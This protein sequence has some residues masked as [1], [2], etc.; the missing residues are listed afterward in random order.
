MGLSPRVRGNLT[1][2]AWANGVKRSIPACT[3]EPSRPRLPLSVARVYPRVYGG[4]FGMRSVLPVRLGLSPRVRG[5]LPDAAR[6]LLDNRSIPACAGEPAINRESR[7][8][9]W[10]YPRVCGGTPQTER[11]QTGYYGL[12]PRVRGNPEVMTPGISLQRSIPACAGEPAFFCHFSGKSQVYPRV[13]GGT[14]LKEGFPCINKGL[15]PR[16][17]GNLQ[18]NHNARAAVG[19]IPA[20]A[21]E[22]FVQSL[23]RIIRRVYPRVC[24]GTHHVTQM[25]KA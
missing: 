19:S 5:N 11:P 13:C 12:S 4:T 7:R 14:L 3:G 17:R 18:D 8:S 20:C 10:V 21:G 22:P 6:T 23:G 15:S 2:K 9:L 1:N 24:G 25:Q 16:V